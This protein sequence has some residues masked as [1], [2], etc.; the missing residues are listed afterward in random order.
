MKQELQKYIFEQ[1]LILEKKQELL[2]ENRVL[3]GLSAL[4]LSGAAFF[5][6]GFLQNDNISTNDV[7]SKAVKSQKL[8]QDQLKQ[9]KRGAELAKRMIDKGANPEEISERQK[10]S[11]ISTVFKALFDNKLSKSEMLANNMPIASAED[12]DLNEMFFFTQEELDRYFDMNEN[13]LSLDDGTSLLD[14]NEEELNS[15]LSDPS[16]E[17]VKLIA[18][19]ILSASVIEN[20][21]TKATESIFDEYGDDPDQLKTALKRLEKDHKNEFY[22]I[23]SVRNFLNQK[24]VDDEAKS[25]LKDILRSARHITSTDDVDSWI[26][27][28]SRGEKVNDKGQFIDG[29]SDYEDDDADIDLDN[30]FKN[31]SRRNIDSDLSSFFSDDLEE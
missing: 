17:V 10:D 3:A 8:T 6:Q 1:I 4:A 29:Y 15:A 11:S 27:D 20:D 30:E 9:I 28:Y 26:N 23:K 14:F 13:V 19:E 18:R 24:V 22:R 2:E 7:A 31:R 21:F 25:T 12:I 16:S 5:A